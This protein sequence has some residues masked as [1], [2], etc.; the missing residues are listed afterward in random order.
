[1]RAL[2]ERDRGFRQQDHISAARERHFALSLDR[3]TLARQMD[4]RRATR[5]K[6]CP[7]RY[8]G[9]M[10]AQQV[11]QPP[12]RDAVSRTGGGVAVNGVQARRASTTGEV[13]GGK[14]EEDAHLAATRLQRSHA[15]RAQGFP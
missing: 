11:G 10:H 8:V 2:E 13:V 6:P 3:R 9:S 12:G 4:R 1:M 15:G 7:T 14:T 5:N